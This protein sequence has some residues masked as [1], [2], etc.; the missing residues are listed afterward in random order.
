M[1]YKKNKVA[2]PIAAA[3]CLAVGGGMLFADAANASSAVQWD[4]ARSIEVSAS[5]VQWDDASVENE[6]LYGYE[7]TVPERTVTSTGSR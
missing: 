3:C 7:F 1:S 4:G 6:Y 5:S 2:I